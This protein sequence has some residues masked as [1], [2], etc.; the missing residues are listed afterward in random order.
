M[1]DW[2]SVAAAGVGGLVAAAASYLTGRA[3]G[4]R[5][6]ESRREEQ[7]E[8]ARKDSL[9]LRRITYTELCSA[10]RHYRSAL[11][12]YVE[13]PHDPLSSQDRVGDERLLAEARQGLEAARQAFAECHSTSQMIVP[14]TILR[15]A[16]DSSRALGDAYRALVRT[17]RIELDPVRLFIEDKVGKELWE[18]RAAMRAD[19]GI[20]IQDNDA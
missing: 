1:S 15:K 14:D 3:D 8:A 11:L 19:L 7:S 2:S 10:A 13:A 18:L 9:A 20:S 17:S 16:T 5:Q 4:R 12:D 6:R